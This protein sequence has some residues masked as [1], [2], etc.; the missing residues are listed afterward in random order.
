MP[1]RSSLINFVNFLGRIASSVRIARRRSDSAFS[2]AIQLTSWATFPAIVVRS[3]V[4]ISY[5]QFFSKART[6]TWYCLS[7]VR[8][9]ALVRIIG[10]LGN[11]FVVFWACQSG[12]HIRAGRIKL[13]PRP[14]LEPREILFRENIC[15]LDKFLR[16]VEYVLLGDGLMLSKV[17]GQ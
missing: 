15:I 11:W 7:E 8:L 12:G 17:G 16:K 10:L 3:V 2:T 6:F 1:D 13:L 14:R 4:E 5:V 9:E